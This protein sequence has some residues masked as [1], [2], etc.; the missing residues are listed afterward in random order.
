M[1]D[2]GCLICFVD[3]FSINLTV[4]FIKIKLILYASICIYKKQLRNTFFKLAVKFFLI[5]GPRLYSS[6][7]I[8]ELNIS[9]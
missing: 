8:T 5:L 4:V 1:W 6:I 7:S 3:F 2:R 9:L